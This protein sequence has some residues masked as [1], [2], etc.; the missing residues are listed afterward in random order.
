MIIGIA[1]VA[2]CGKNLF[3]TKLKEKLTKKGLICN[4]YSFARQL[5]VELAPVLKT[6]FDLDV[7]SQDIKEK[8]K[9]RALMT[10][11]ADIHRKETRGAYFWKKTQELIKSEG[12]EKN[13]NI[14][15]DLRFAE[16]EGTDEIDFVRKNGV[17][18]HLRKYEIVRGKKIF[19]K[20]ANDFEKFN[21]PLVKKGANI[22]IDWPDARKVPYSVDLDSYV[23][24]F[25]HK[26]ERSFK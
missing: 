2:T 22:R 26:Y 7:W 13:I 3:A 24:Q 15:T 17:A 20:P 5:R 19:V 23:D 9:F 14:I 16:Y 6:N 10:V 11:W 12:N 4:E 25:I 18:I 8:Q 1:G 21:D